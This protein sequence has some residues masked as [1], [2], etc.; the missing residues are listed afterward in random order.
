MNKWTYFF[1]GMIPGIVIGGVATF[2]LLLGVGYIMQASEELSY[3]P[4]EQ[5]WEEANYKSFKVM[6][7]LEDHSALVEAKDLSFDDKYDIYLG[8]T[9]L[10]V[11]DGE[12]YYY[13]DEVIKV[14]EGKQA[15]QVGRYHY[16][17]KGG[18]DKTVSVIKIVDK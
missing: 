4:I 2:V 11:N 12:K 14:P 17:T 6:Q 9:F 16:T 13:D 15:M 1:L 8:P 5:P 10:L 3:T 7:V 18:S